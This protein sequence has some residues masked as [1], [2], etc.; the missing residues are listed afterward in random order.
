MY[1]T[2]MTA[3]DDLIP[4]ARNPRKIDE[5]A[6]TKLASMIREFGFQVPVVALP[7]HTVVDG[8]MRLL[9]AQKLGLSEVPVHTVTDWSEAKAK[10]FRIAVNQA[11]TLAEWD[12]ELLSTELFDLKELDTPLDVLGFDELHIE[13]LLH[14]I[15]DDFIPDLPADD[16][17]KSDSNSYQITVQCKDEDEQQMIFLEL[18]D[19]GLTVKAK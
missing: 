13:R 14:P 9:A 3:I 8:H 10:A 15:A 12:T 19:R 17:E 2:T 1:T 6:I 11:A 7:D 18:R 5:S 4:Y 16:E